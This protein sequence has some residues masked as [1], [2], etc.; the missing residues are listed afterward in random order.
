MKIKTAYHDSDP[1]PGLTPGD[2]GDVYTS[3]TGVE[4]WS[5]YE[6]QDPA[7]PRLS[8]GGGGEVR[9]M[10]NSNTGNVFGNANVEIKLNSINSSKVKGTIQIPVNKNMTKS[11]AGHMFTEDNIDC[12]NSYNILQ[13][14]III[15]CNC[16]RRYLY[17]AT[18]DLSLFLLISLTC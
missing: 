3:P 11:H 7:L 18:N 9:L 8:P 10:D 15:R 2:R 6:V 1:P 13:R 14:L 16:S 12:Q 17:I 4:K 5:E